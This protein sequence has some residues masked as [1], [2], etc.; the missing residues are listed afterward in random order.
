MKQSARY[1]ALLPLLFT[2]A[3]YAETVASTRV[4]DNRAAQGDI[5]SLPLTGQYTHYAP[6]K[7]SGKPDGVID[8]TARHEKTPNGWFFQQHEPDLL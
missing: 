4:L 8:S 5:T 6:D 1:I 3:I 7:K 2:P